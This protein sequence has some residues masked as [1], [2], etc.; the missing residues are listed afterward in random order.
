MTTNSSTAAKPVPGEDLPRLAQEVFRRL[1][2]A[3]S[4][5]EIAPGTRLVERDIA[6]QLGVSRM[7]VRTAIEKLIEYGFATKEPHHVAYV[8]RFSFK[9][10]DEVYSVRVALEQLVVEYA[11]AHWSPD[12]YQTLRDIVDEMSEPSHDSTINTSQ[13]VVALD[14]RFHETLWLLT[15]H[16]LVIETVAGLR[17]RISR[18]LA[19]A[20]EALSDQAMEEHIQT[21]YRLLDVFQ[22]GDVSAAKAEITNHILIAK[23]RIATHFDYLPGYGSPPL[24]LRRFDAAG[25]NKST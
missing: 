3:I 18:F 9:E 15:E 1:H 25:K 7:P 23:Q 14:R 12:A 8:H 19:E 13:N 2:E 24:A 16:Q 10:L 5:G 22:T 21:H 6:E 4:T 17:S 11:L 20:T